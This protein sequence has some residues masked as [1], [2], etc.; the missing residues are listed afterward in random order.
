[1]SFIKYPHLE[2]FGTDEVDGI[3]VGQCHIFPKIDGT[4]ASFWWEG[5]KLHCGSRNRELS[6]D[7]DNAGFMAWALQQP[8]LNELARLYPDCVFYGEWLVPHSLKTYREDAWRKL[9][10]F[11]VF[12]VDSGHFVPYDTYQG[13]LAAHG[14]DYIPCLGVGTNPTY[15][16]LSGWRDRNTY[17][18]QDGKGPGEGIVIKQYGWTNRFGRTT[19][20]KLVTNH[21]KEENAKT[22]G[23][24][25]INCKMLEDEIAD[26]FV[27]KHLVDKV[28]AKIRN[29][30]GAFGARNIP[31][32]L[33]TVWHDLVTEEAWEIVKKHK[34]PKIDF[35]TLNHCTIARVK[36]HLP[37]LFGLRVED[38]QPVAEAA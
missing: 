12:N 25:L 30:Q 28:V 1:M 21:F 5:G 19:W 8:G 18:L 22:F 17:L 37:E 9:Y 24:S 7:N 2:R 6:L 16:V 15:E 11:D 14:V 35:K 3:N 10:V 29:D 27:T 36:Q 4:N 13:V 31:Q 38:S 20:A 34:N 32:L 26:E 33:G 23:P